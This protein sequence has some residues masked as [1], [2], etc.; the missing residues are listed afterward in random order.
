VISACD[1]QRERVQFIPL[2]VW[3]AMPRIAPRIA[4]PPRIAGTATPGPNLLR[5][6]VTAEA[7]QRA[8]ARQRLGAQRISEAV[9]VANIPVMIIVGH[10]EGR[11][12]ARGSDA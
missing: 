12:A 2:T 11:R 9:D 1:T 6:Q 7:Q 10:V 4:P 3:P 5:Y 8:H